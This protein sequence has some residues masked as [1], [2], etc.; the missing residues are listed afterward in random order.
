MNVLYTSLAYPPSI[1]GGEIHLHRL[2][3]EVASNGC[4]VHVINQWS[5]SRTDWI[6]GST[7]RCRNAVN[8]RQDDIEVTRLGFNAST[9][10]RM[11]PWLHAYRLKSSRAIAI[12]G[13]ARLMAPYYEIAASGNHDL[14][15]V[16][17][18][19]CEFLPEVALQYCRRHDL[20]FVITALHH[21]D[22]IGKK[23]RHYDRIFRSADAVI[24]LT[25]SERRTLIETRSVDARRVHVTG[26][27]PILAPDYSVEAFRDRF[28]LRGRYL[29]FVG[30]KAPQKGWAT[31]LEAAP[32]ILAAHED[33]SIVFIGPDTRASENAFA[34][35]DDAR[36]INLGTV[37]L[38]TKTAA[39]AGCELL[40]LPST[41]ESFGGVFAE[42]W[43]FGKPVVGVNIPS[44][45]CVV[46]DGSD[47]LLVAPECDPL[48][49]AVSEL[50]AN[51]TRAAEMGANG[52]RKVKEQHNWKR[53]AEKTLAIYRGVSSS[54]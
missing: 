26:I 2:A 10:M 11:W 1:G 28:D 23:F 24:A 31:L 4:G 33:T 49:D 48:A 14:I 50:L 17:R 38:A 25:E 35:T 13:V 5:S 53:I 22:Y 6:R 45:A 27:G 40:A 34:A 37:D 18:M 21:P 29:L 30:R 43:S 41:G 39:I 32:K 3:S 51:P 7:T 20:P 47:G 52:L 36:V 16:L 15:H 8:Y 12:E 44:V 42:A 9:R 54:I 19:G 46:T